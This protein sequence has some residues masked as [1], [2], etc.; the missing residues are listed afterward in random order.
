MWTTYILHDQYVDFLR[1][2]GNDDIYAWDLKNQSKEIEELYYALTYKILSLRANEI[3]AWKAKE[4]NS[5]Y[6]SPAFTRTNLGT[7]SNF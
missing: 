7:L 3:A 5:L 1:F 4:L 6:M 2:C